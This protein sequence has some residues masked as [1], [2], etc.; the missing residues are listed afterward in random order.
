MA[1]PK[2]QEN[3][4]RRR[5][6]ILDADYIPKTE[7]PN[8][9]RVHSAPQK[10]P[11]SSL[12][13][14]TVLIALL[15][16]AVAVTRGGGA[17]PN[18]AREPVELA[19]EAK[20]PSVALHPATTQAP[21]PRGEAS[22]GLTAETVRPPV[23]AYYSMK[24]S[25]LVPGAQVFALDENGPAAAAGLRSG[26]VITAVNGTPILTEEDLYREEAGGRIGET[27]ELT[28]FRE[29]DYL[30]VKAELGPRTENDAND[31]FHSVD[32]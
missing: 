27:L 20:V 21:V 30:T 18:A 17:F 26:D 28:V 24:D 25:P 1:D 22:L 14:L 32:D 31:F 3:T 8:M 16:V 19:R 6:E 13:V 23:A 12:T 5:T 9:P 10:G 15:A 29:G 2:Q 7:I 11:V 4:T